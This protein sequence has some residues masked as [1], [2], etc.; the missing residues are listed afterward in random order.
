M[1]QKSR[2]G[3]L[4][5]GMM[6]EKYYFFLNPYPNHAFTRCP[7][8]DGKTKQK[9]LPLTIELRKR[10]MFLNINKTCRFCENCE[11]LI[12][13]QQEMEQILADA[14]GENISKKD[15]FIMGTLDK[16]HYTECASTLGESRLF[17]HLFVFKDQWIFEKMPRYV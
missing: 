7:K 2:H 6:P 14:F 16:E 15:Y 8:C 12:A 4:K 10:K 11:L 9:K 5:A 17:E 3:K 1:R 13:K